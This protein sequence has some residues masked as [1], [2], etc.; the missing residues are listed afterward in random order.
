M[1]EKNLC[2]C[3][4]CLLAIESHEGQQITRKI[5]WDG[6]EETPFICDWCDDDMETELYE[7]L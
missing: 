7:I 6:D 5:Y 3:W 2:V 4:R 1:E